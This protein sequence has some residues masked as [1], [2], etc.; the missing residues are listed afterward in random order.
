MKK[1]VSI[2]IP[3]YNGKNTLK[4]ALAGIYMQKADNDI[5][6]IIIDDCSR[7]TYYE[8]IFQFQLLGLDIKYI[9][10]K[11]NLGAGKSRQIGIDSASGEFIAFSDADDY[12]DP[13]WFQKIKKCIEKY[14]HISVFHFMLYVKSKNN[15]YLKSCHLGS[16][17]IKKSFINENEIKFHDNLRIYE[18]LYYIE[19]VIN[20]AVYLNR[21]KIIDKILYYYIDDNKNSTLHRLSKSEED[22]TNL[23][24]F[25]QAQKVYWI[26]NNKPELIVH[27]KEI[28]DKYQDMY[29]KIISKTVREPDQWEENQ[30]IQTKNQA[31]TAYGG[32]Q[33]A[34]R[35]PY[36]LL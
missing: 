29:E 31:I 7:D 14:P 8:D 6:I 33:S 5:E 11:K 21:F 1:T 3:V 28:K 24:N 19:I 35:N 10:N 15:A 17:L 36:T 26:L 12:I 25:A 18:D 23:K 30:K 13:A 32:N 27:S 20:I 9:R 22:L 16:Y 34:K 4:S 2:I